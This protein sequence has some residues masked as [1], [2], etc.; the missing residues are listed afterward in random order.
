ML[1]FLAKGL[2]RDRSR[3]LFPLLT[4]AIGVTLVVFMDS[5]LRGAT[6]AMFA[7]TASFVCG[8]VRVATRAY[9]KAGADATNELA[10]LG[11]DSILGE[12]KR[13]FPDVT[14]TLR[15]RFGGLVD[16]PDSMGE[17]RV[18]SP[19]AGMAIDLSPESPERKILRL[20]QSL[21]SGHLPSAPGEVLLSDDFARRLD[22]KPGDKL[23]LVSST[24]NGSMATYNFT[25]SGTVRFGVSAMDRGAVLADIND[26]QQA[27]D[28]PDAAD[29]VFGFLPVAGY[30][31]RLASRLAARFNSGRDT[32]DR[33]APVMETMRLASGLGSMFDLIGAATGL[34]VSI[35]IVAMAV[36]LWNAGLMGSLR[37]YGEVGVRLA[38]GESKPAVYRSLL[39]ES[40]LIGLAGSVLGTLA[41]LGLG[42]Y[43]QEVGIDISGMMPN[44]TVV[45]DDVLR[46]RVTPVSVYI[47]FVPG[48]LATFVGAAIS[49]L[50][51][52]KRQTAMLAKE[53]GS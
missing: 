21:A 23:T 22:V 40:F 12:L 41:G 20:E 53:L 6:D 43:L 9:A 25:L 36:V 27:L 11:V 18:Q 47:G 19:A 45:I 52:F 42:Y 32:T 2:L 34:I 48:L 33:Y 17:T 13:D 26:I 10:L 29:A 35:F 8:H 1:T 4:V 28:M 24:M 51:V 14:W 39:A 50:G 15:T 5:Y 38:I 3:S 31:D 49:G 46:A 7:A 16:V 37:R 30:D 44:A